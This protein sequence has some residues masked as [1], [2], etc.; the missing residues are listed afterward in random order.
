MAPHQDVIVGIDGSAPSEEAAAWALKKLRGSGRTLRLVHVITPVH[1]EGAA[2]PELRAAGE[3]M[4]T[5]LAARLAQLDAA[6][7]DDTSDTVIDTEVV[8]GDAAEALNS[9]ADE[10]SLLVL[11]RPGAGQVNSRRLGTVSF[12]LPG[13][14]LSSVLVHRVGTGSEFDGHSRADAGPVVVGLDTSEYAAVAALDAAEFAVGNGQRLRI[15]VGIDASAEHAAIRARAESDLAW[16][17]REFPALDADVELATGDPVDALIRASE[18]ADLIVVGKRGLG[19]FAA[20][21]SQLG[22]TS[23]AVLTDAQSSVLLVTFR[24]DP[25]LESRT[26]ATR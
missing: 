5:G 25:R 16:L 14:A 1:L 26:S 10:A 6:H 18:D 12:G 23:S 15:L 22:R 21:T 9:L 3:K 17:R 4:L 7:P 11:G 24:P 8:I 2:E 19:Q 13:H 20:M